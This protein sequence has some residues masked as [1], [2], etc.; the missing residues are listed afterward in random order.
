MRNRLTKL[1]VTQVPN[2]EEA[3]LKYKF[4]YRGTKYYDYRF[5]CLNEVDRTMAA[6]IKCH[7][8]MLKEA[9]EK[10]SVEVNSGSI[11]VSYVQE[12][13]HLLYKNKAQLQGFQE[14]ERF[15][16]EITPQIASLDELHTEFMQ[17]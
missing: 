14:L 2:D 1:S 3:K 7:E 8:I 17:G 12:R 13:A 5:I 6:I 4:K 15:E 9:T 11:R 10:A 16:S